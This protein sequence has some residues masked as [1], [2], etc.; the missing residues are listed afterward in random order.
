MKEIIGSV[1]LIVLII[2]TVINIYATATKK[3]RDG[4]ARL[5]YEALF[6]PI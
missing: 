4:S 5:R 2:I 3:K 6:E 1:V